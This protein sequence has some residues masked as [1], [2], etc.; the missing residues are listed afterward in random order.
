M[1]NPFVS[2]TRRLALLLAVSGL[3]S[4]AGAAQAQVTVNA[5]IGQPGFYGQVHIGNVAPQVIYQQPVMVQRPVY[6]PPMQPVYLRVP[7]VHLRHWP[8]YCAQYN[9]CGVPVYFVR[10]DWYRQVYAPSVWAPPPLMAQPAMPQPMYAPPV[11]VSPPPVVVA[12]AAPVMVQPGW[13]GHG[14]HQGHWHRW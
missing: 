9:A 1:S 3:A 7:H 6:G 11:V 12:Q 4:W 2:H 8:T 5:Q 14:H 13:R 10:D